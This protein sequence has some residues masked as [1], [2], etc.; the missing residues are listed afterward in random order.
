MESTKHQKN[1]QKNPTINRL[2][3]IENDLVVAEERGVGD[4][5]NRRRGLRGTN[6]YFT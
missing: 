6:I 3:N 4:E 5:Y 2:I 1:N